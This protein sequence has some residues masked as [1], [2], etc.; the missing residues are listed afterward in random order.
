VGGAVEDERVFD[1]R[2]G[3]SSADYGAGIVVGA[4]SSD[5]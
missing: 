4:V 3:N 1:L 2:V 5:F